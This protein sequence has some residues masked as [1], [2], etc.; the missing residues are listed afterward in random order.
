M[1]DTHPELPRLPPY[2]LNAN[3]RSPTVR[4]RLLVRASM[5]IATPPGPYPS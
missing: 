3:R 1:Y 2:L 5:I 4:V